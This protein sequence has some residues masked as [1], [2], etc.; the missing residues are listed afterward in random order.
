MTATPTSVDYSSALTKDFFS[1]SAILVPFTKSVNSRGNDVYKGIAKN[2]P[3]VDA[4]GVTVVIEFTKSAAQAKTVYDG[5]VAAKQNEGY[6][7]Y[8][9]AVVGRKL[10]QCMGPYV[11]WKHMGAFFHEGKYVWDG[12][13]GNN[14]ASCDIQCAPQYNAWLVTTEF[15]ASTAGCT[16]TVSIDYP[17]SGRSKLIE[18][19]IE[20]V[21]PSDSRHYKI[22]AFTVNWVSNTEAK[23]HIE[24]YTASHNVY[25]KDITLTHFPSTDAATDYYNSKAAYTFSGDWVFA[26]HVDYYKLTGK[27]PTV[28]HANRDGSANNG[29]IQY[30]AFVVELTSSKM[31]K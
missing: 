1:T 2:I 9:D 16:K 18:G 5:A 13:K 7:Y 25:V 29:V 22:Q 28:F 24:L 4:S 31:N 10:I 21:R 20:W 26:P 6:V 23:V 19:A 8:A 15:F 12:K 17:T 3:K 30:D 27:A 14:R 11:E